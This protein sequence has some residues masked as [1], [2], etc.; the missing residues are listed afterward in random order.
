[1]KTPIPFGT[2]GILYLADTP[3]EQGAFTLVPGFQRWGEDWLKAL[4]PGAHPREQNL[5]ALGP[6]PI[7]GRAGDLIIWHQSLPHGASPNRG[8]KPQLVQYVNIF[9]TRIEEQEEWI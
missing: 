5:Y 8:R 2:A 7:G 4:P 9:P 6:Q 3:P 1:V